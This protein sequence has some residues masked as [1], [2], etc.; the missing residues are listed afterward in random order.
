MLKKDSINEK[1]KTENRELDAGAFVTFSSD[2]MCAYITIKDDKDRDPISYEDL[3]DIIESENVVY[4]I[5]TKNLKSMAEAPIYG[6]PICI[7]KG[8]APINGE[9]GVV[10][11]HFD[12]NQNPKPSISIDGKVD[13]R[14]LNIVESVTKGQLLCTISPPTKGKAGRDVTGKLINAINGRPA[15][16]PKGKNVEIGEDGLSLFSMLAGQVR[17]INEKISVFPVYEVPEDVD[18]S[19]GN[20]SFIGDVVVKK[21]VISGFTI[22]AG[23]N[24]EVWGVVE[25]ATIKAEGDIFLKCGMQGLGKGILISGGDII[26]RYIENSNVEAKN[27]IEAD[28]I[29]HSNIKCGGKLSLKGRNGLLVGGIYCAGKEISAKTIGSQMATNTEIEV[30]INPN[31]RADC[32]KIRKSIIEIENNLKKSEQA[33]S[34]LT[35]LESI[36]ELNENKKKMLLK[37]IR[38]KVHYSSQLNELREELSKME[39]AFQKEM[40]G[41]IHCSRRLYYGTK[42]TIGTSSMFVKENL[43]RCTIHLEANDIRVGTYLG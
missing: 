2:K 21:N 17:Y 20:I 31:L 5:N 9:N 19:T 16:V 35:K 33:V 28:S 14:E 3:K 29:M 12:K 1:T 11:L 26:A 30:G 36:E 22:E 27:D 38:T 23:G 7:T 40:D 13:L 15:R 43:D 18:N 42:I 4:G 8:T 6:Q 39:S 24:V 34:I 41:K 25:G 32:E 37:S 10:K